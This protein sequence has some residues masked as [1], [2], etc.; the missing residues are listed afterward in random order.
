M[1]VTGGMMLAALAEGKLDEPIKPPTLQD[2]LQA[3]VDLFKEG[4]IGNIELANRLYSVQADEHVR[5]KLQMG[6][7]EDMEGM[8]PFLQFDK[9]ILP[10]LN[11]LLK[12]L[13]LPIK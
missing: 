2:K 10:A 4:L 13:K 5:L 9:E 6:T 8:A 7:K 3:E 12:A 1:L 11:N